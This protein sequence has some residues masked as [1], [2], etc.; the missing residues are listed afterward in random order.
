MHQLNTVLGFEI[1]I[2]VFYSTHCKYL[3][4]LASVV[5]ACIL[6]HEKHA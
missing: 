2:K 5:D 1:V 6:M 3:E 4:Q